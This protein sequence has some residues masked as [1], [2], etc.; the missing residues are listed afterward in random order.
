MHGS[1]GKECKESPCND[2]PRK[3]VCR[4]DQ[5][6]PLL[7][8]RWVLTL[9]GREGRRRSLCLLGRHAEDETI[10]RAPHLRGQALGDEHELP[11]LGEVAIASDPQ[12]NLRCSIHRMSRPLPARRLDAAVK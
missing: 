2:K 5:L 7:R 8:L 3:Q 12:G 11:L 4:P 9:V 6:V 10:V 1:D